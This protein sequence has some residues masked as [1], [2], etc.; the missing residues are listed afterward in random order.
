ME[1]LGVIAL[2]ISLILL[3]IFIKFIKNTRDKILKLTEEL[4]NYSTQ[5]ENSINNI[6]KN[7]N[8]S[9]EI[10]VTKFNNNGSK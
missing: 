9:N 10:I 3:F 5:L 6:V 4:Q 8:D 2:F 1:T 7:I